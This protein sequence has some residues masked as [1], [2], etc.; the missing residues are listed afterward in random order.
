MNIKRIPT[1]CS[2]TGR[3]K[4]IVS[5][6]KVTRKSYFQL[7]MWDMYSCF[8]IHRPKIGRDIRLQ[9]HYQ[10]YIW[11]KDFLCVNMT[12]LETYILGRTYIRLLQNHTNSQ[13]HTPCSISCIF[14]VRWSALDLDR[15]ITY[16]VISNLWQKSFTKSP[17]H[18]QKPCKKTCTDVLQQTSCF[19]R[20]PLN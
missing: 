16:P 8:T 4:S 5:I 17:I 19:T 14:S 18:L 1:N 20:P 11:K 15:F 2:I 13:T 6:S 7:Q 10:M 9:E 12:P 3:I